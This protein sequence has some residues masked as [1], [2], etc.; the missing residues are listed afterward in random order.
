MQ[1]SVGRCVA[2]LFMP[3]VLAAQP[4][5]PSKRDADVLIAAARQHALAYNR[6]LIDFLCTQVTTRYSA[7]TQNG[8]SPEWKPVDT[9]TIR[10]SYFKQKEDYRVVMVNGKKTNKTLDQIGGHRT[11]GEFGSILSQIFAPSSKTEFKWQR[12]SAGDKPLA[13]FSFRIDREHSNFVTNARRFLH[14][15]SYTWGAVGEVEVDPAT[16]Q[17]VQLTLHSAQMPDDSPARD[18]AISISYAMQNVGD[19]DYLLP[20]KSESQVTIWGQTVKAESHFKD[21]QKF[22]ADTDIKF[23]TA[24]AD[25]P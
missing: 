7:K 4:A 23:D 16:R 11:E 1:I 18:V 9:L 12:W 6:A 21:Y 17:V 25:K 3:A 10:V 22:A 2:V 8:Q 24:P 20:V 13:V 5:P 19:T 14:S 15:G